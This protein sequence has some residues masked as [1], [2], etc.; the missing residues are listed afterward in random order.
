[1]AALSSI[2]RTRKKTLETAVDE[3]SHSWAAFEFALGQKGVGGESGNPVLLSLASLVWQADGGFQLSSA[4]ADPKKF[5]V[6]APVTDA[7]QETALNAP[8]ATQ[9]SNSVETL[10]TSQ[11]LPSAQSPAPAD[12][13]FLFLTRRVDTING[14][15]GNNTFF[16]PAGTVQSKDSLIGGSGFNA[17]HLTLTAAS[18]SQVFA[19]YNLSLEKI[20]HVS[21]ELGQFANSLVPVELSAL[22]WSGIEQVRFSQSSS[23]NSIISI[24]HLAINP[25]L[26]FSHFAGTIFAQYDHEVGTNDLSVILEDQSNV[27]L[28]V[29]PKHSFDRI[30]I[31]SS[32][33]GT[34]NLVIDII[35]GEASYPRVMFLFGNAPLHI[36]AS[37]REFS[38]LT[39][40]DARNLA[41][42]LTLTI[43]DPRPITVQGGIG[44]DH[45]IL[46]GAVHGA[47]S[48]D[49]G[50]GHDALS[51][52]INSAPSFVSTTSIRS[53][54]HLVA[55]DALHASAIIRNSPDFDDIFLSNSI[56]QG[57]SLRLIGFDKIILGAD[58]NGDLSVT[59]ETP[60]TI[61]LQEGCD[62]ISSLS[63]LSASD[64]T[65]NGNADFSITSLALDG[66]QIS[67]RFSGSSYVRIQNVDP[68]FPDVG[69]LIDLSN[70]TGG[71]DNNFSGAA[72]S[73]GS[74]FL[75]GDF[76]RQSSVRLD[77]TPHAKSEIVFGAELHARIIIYNM[78]LGDQ[79]DLGQLGVSDFGNLESSFWS[80]ISHI[81]SDPFAGAFDVVGIDLTSPAQ[82]SSYV[83]FNGHFG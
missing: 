49:G 40:I 46:T 71:F 10:S 30:D 45:L 54:E 83:D 2:G 19:Q 1:M 9:S 79:I 32:G 78:A 53:V 39:S 31:T 25:V 55:F 76:H 23:K 28:S 67:L 17:A 6:T 44:N 51:I 75:I 66:A 47:S 37:D 7:G 14:A 27:R 52:D 56:D 29:L 57:A 70:L 58:I 60:L 74:D 36:Q 50:T 16:G 3:S 43:A 11:Q 35:G 69:D 68:A 26:A 42:G 34:N 15:E 5:D 80:G 48:F 21:F 81:V 4:F 33:D 8:Q 61:E 20:E 22:Q 82:A 62:A 12:E 38:G 65:V 72:F 73:G 18:A 24:E 13:T 63:F 64:V 41:G 59:S 77:T